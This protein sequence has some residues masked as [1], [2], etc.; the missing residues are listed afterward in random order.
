VGEALGTQSRG[1]KGKRPNGSER[2]F[3]Q[4][5][6]T[7]TQDVLHL[8]KKSKIPGKENIIAKEQTSKKKNAQGQLEGALMVR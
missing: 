5:K 7:R 1:G 8:Q 3:L 2:G 4:R 6:F